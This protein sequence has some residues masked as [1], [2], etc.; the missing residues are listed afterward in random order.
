[1]SMFLSFLFLFVMNLWDFFIDFW[2]EP[3]V[4]YT[5][6]KYHLPLFDLLI[7]A[8]NVTASLIIKSISFSPFFLVSVIC[9]YNI[10]P[11]EFCS[12]LAARSLQDNI[13]PILR[14][15]ELNN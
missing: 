3:F 6:R 8:I 9:D 5:Y 14:K 10:F 15:R 7:H 4:G 13:A 2:F 11:E 12:H 1:M